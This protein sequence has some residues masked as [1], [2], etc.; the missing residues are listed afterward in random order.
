MITLVGLTLAQ[1]FNLAKT[2]DEIN[3][4]LYEN[5]PD[6]IE[7]K[8]WSDQPVELKKRHNDYGFERIDLS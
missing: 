4:Y 1:E 5:Y 7:D 3:A 2:L 6:F 8:E